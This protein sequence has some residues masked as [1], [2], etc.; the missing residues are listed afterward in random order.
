MFPTTASVREA[1]A[2]VPTFPFILSSTVCSPFQNGSQMG[3]KRIPGGGRDC[4]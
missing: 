4:H 2:L 1:V 3:D